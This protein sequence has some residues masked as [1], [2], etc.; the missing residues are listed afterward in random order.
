MLK[1][2][3]FVI[4]ILFVQRRNKDTQSLIYMMAPID[5]QELCWA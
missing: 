2:Q 1:T 4:L 5:S 3:Q